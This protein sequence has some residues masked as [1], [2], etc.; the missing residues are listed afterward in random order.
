[1]RKYKGSEGSEALGRLEMD[2]N[3]WLLEHP[4]KVEQSKA[5]KGDD[6]ANFY[7]TKSFIPVFIGPCLC[8][9]ASRM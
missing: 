2:R 8:I 5:E 7:T 4:L 9:V 3:V 6:S 1:V